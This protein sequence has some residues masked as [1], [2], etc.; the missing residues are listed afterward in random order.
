MDQFKRVGN[1]MHCKHFD[2]KLKFTSSHSHLSSLLRHLRQKH[3]IFAMENRSSEAI[4][5]KLSKLD[6]Y[7]TPVSISLPSPPA[8]D[9][10]AIAACA[11]NHV[12]PLD[13]VENPIFQWAYG[14]ACKNRAQLSA[15]ISEIAADWRAM[16]RANLKGK[17]LCVMLDGWT[18]SLN[19]DHHLCFIVGQPGELFHWKST[20][21]EDKTAAGISRELSKILHEVNGR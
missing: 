20:V 3:P 4:T 11:G 13:I 21:I 5:N 2:V 10:Q 9:R 1:E 15:R 18:N 6:D 14:A 19:G 8:I 12:L 16:I 17:H 7:F